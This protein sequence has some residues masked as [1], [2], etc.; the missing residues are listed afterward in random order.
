M[1]VATKAKEPG[2]SI[3]IH[4]EAIYQHPRSRVWRA[5]T[6]PALLGKW[7]MQPEGFAP[8]V[9]TRFILRAG[10]PHRGWRGFVECEVLAVEEGRLL[11]YSWN[12][13]PDSPPLLLTLRLEDAEGGT[14]LVL[15]HEGFAGARGWM[16]AKL[17]MGPGWGRMLRKRLPAVLEGVA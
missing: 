13:D 16:L 4:R 14:R 17:M 1:S 15:D 6:E 9:G 5:L 11:R 2:S 8:V 12:G 7:L 3:R 10:E